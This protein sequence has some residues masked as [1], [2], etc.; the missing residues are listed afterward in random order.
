[1]TLRPA[2]NRALS[3]PRSAIREIM[4]LAAG[5]EGVIHLEIGEPDFST[6]AHIVNGALAAAQDG[7]TKYTP[8]P[9]FPALRAQIAD[10]VS[11]RYGN[12]ISADRIVVT[13]GAVGGLYSALMAVTDFGDEI[14]VPDPGWPNYESIVHLAEGR[15]VRF[16]L[17]V[18]D[19]FL[20]NVDAIAKLIT[21]RT[22]AIMINTPGNPTG[23]IMPAATLQAIAD[24]AR[25]HG[26]YVI[27]DEV[28]EDIVFDGDHVSA[29]QFGLDDRLFLISGASKTYAMTG[30][31]LGY[32][33]C[34]EALAP[35]VATLQEPVASCASSVS[36]KAYETALT[37]PQDCVSAFREIY[38]GRRDILLDVL[39]N[40]GLL[41]AVPAGAFYALVDIGAANWEAGSLAFAKRLL[42]EKNVAVVPGITFGPSC[43][44]YVRVA[45]TTDDDSLRKG[46]EILRAFI[47]GNEKTSP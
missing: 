21:D 47:E 40:T 26:L 37:G 1:M 42:L 38:R 6:P 31:R 39:G 46:L 36:Q 23:A 8:N 9:G 29:S 28:Y 15:S 41:P 20:P 24:L 25:Q 7:Y 19:G 18:E 11:A 22:K 14:L 13:V 5:R 27:S 4:A 33:I 45:F 34:P 16:D 44:H 3:M 10:H 17:P 30:W 32:V 43:D 2:A 12:P 35:V